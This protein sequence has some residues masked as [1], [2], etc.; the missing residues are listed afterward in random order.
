MFSSRTLFTVSD[1]SVKTRMTLMPRHMHIL[2]CSLVAKSC[3]TFFATQ[4]T[5]SPPGFS[6]HGI[7]QA[8]ILEWVAISF[9][10]D[11]PHT[12]IEPPF[13]CWQAD[14]LPTSY[15]ESPKCIY[16]FLFICFSLSVFSKFS[17]RK[18][19]CVIQVIFRR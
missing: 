4:G 16:T 19:Y 14:F 8:R 13:L 11:L 7:F 10:R 17:A 5:G 3:R 12:G 2:F 6:G 1:F 9:F 18:V 15:L